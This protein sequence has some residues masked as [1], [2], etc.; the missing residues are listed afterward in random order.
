MTGVQT[1]ALPIWKAGGKSAGIAM[2]V[3]R[4]AGSERFDV[5][6]LSLLELSFPTYAADAVPPELAAI[7]VQKPG[8]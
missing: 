6:A 5:P 4:R 7:P 1:C 3:D 2:L 8:S